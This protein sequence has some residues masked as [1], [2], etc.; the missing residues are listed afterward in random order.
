MQDRY[1][2]D[3]GD[4]AK[5]GLLRHLA[6]ARLG[7]IWY[8]TRLGSKAND[9]RHID[10]LDRP[11]FGECDQEL[12]Q[13]FRHESRRRTVKSFER[14]RA[15]PE[16]TAY[17][18]EKVPAGTGRG[19]WFVR[20]AQEVTSADLVFCDPDNGIASE[21][22]ERAGS[23]RHVFQREIDG[24]WDRGHSL[25][26]YHHCGRN[27]PHAEQIERMLQRLRSLRP[28]LL[29]AARFR[30]YSARVF[31]VLAQSRHAPVLA[32]GLARFSASPWVRAGHFELV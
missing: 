27:R 18:R 7:V 3:I 30:R 6:G 25:V 24:L 8:L 9:G 5:C 19:A 28:S 12:F 1:T 17:A 4:Y 11:E 15:L 31:F 20:A 13:L 23:R 16:T 21:R 29:R 2:F 26:L 14:C 10:Y 22:M 32:E